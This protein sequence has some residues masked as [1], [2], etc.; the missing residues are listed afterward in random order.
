MM[1]KDR[2]FKCCRCLASFASRSNSN[3][4]FCSRGC[5]FAFAGEAGITNVGFAKVRSK[6]FSIA[7][8]SCGEMA[9]NNTKC[10]ACDAAQRKAERIVNSNPW[11]FKKQGRKRGVCLDC[12][13]ASG[14]HESGYAKRW[15]DN[16]YRARHREAVW[17][18][19]HYRR[20][21]EHGVKRERID[22]REVCAR[23]GWTCGICGLKT[24]QALLGTSEPNAPT[25][26]HIVPM[27]KGGSHTYDNV[28]CACH[29]CNSLKS[30]FDMEPVVQALPATIF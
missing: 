24:N 9:F 3:N 14:T 29:L 4:L 7:W 15:C 20:A 27:S 2:V 10:K 8:C 25:V 5:A 22:R 21:Q 13:R 28:Q 26:D 1:K 6:T 12:G 18:E 11:Y 19:K 17:M 23:Y 30:D 16:C